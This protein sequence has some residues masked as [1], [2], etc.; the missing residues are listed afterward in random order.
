[1]DSVFYTKEESQYARQARSFFQTDI[2]PHVESMDRENKY[3]FELLSLMAQRHYI[4]VR[5]PTSFGGGG[6]DMMHE[7][8][9]NE[10]AGAQSYAL[11]CARSVPHHVAHVIHQFG[12]P[13]QRNL[14]L[15][16]IF[17]AQ[18][19][20]SQCVSEPEAGS[21]AARIRTR[22]V[23]E[24]SSY[25]ISGEK[26][27]M[28]SGAVADL[29]LVFAITDPNLHPRDGMSAFAVERSTPGI[30]TL[31]EFDTMGWRGLRIVSQMIFNNVRVPKEALVGDEN[32]GY[33]I[34]LE[35]LDA[36][37]IVVSAGLLGP[38]RSCLEIAARYSMSRHAFH[39]P[40]RQFEA[41][42]LRVAEM[43]TRI[44]ASRLLRIKAARMFDHA[45]GVTKIAA[46]AKVFAAETA[47]WVSNEALQIM[48][49][50][51]F[52]TQYPIERHFRDARGGMIAAGTSEI[53]NLI[54]Q[55]Q[56]YKELLSR[57]MEGR[58]IEADVEISP[59]ETQEEKIYE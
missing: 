50:I 10:E 42:S 18:I 39:R 33:P 12:T 21:D 48:G 9:V 3:P 38:A 44:E 49:G 20:V 35:M 26:R 23:R 46:M 5:F 59:Q 1:M 30:V 37:R 13:E 14:Y 47:F 45:M 29:L 6:R 27:F 36:E 17:N 53:M 25:V 43:A 19:I 24:G 7:T 34:L 2:A 31:E 54:I 4:G 16:G 32:V 8:M 41:I 28:A 11:A 15:P 51:G 22:A 52:T 57:G 40:L 55:H 58:D 56:Y